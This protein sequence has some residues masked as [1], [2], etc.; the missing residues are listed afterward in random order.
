MEITNKELKTIL[1]KELRTI[2]KD[3]YLDVSNDSSILSGN[4]SKSD[5]QALTASK[6]RETAMKRIDELL[7][8]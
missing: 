2:M 7:K 8:E 4:P 3:A 6:F 1:H 5:V